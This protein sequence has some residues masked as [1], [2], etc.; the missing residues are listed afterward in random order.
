MKEKLIQFAWYFSIWFLFMIFTVIVAKP[1]AD[2]NFPLPTSS[3]FINTIICFLIPYI[4][5]RKFMD[6]K[7]KHDIKIKDIVGVVGIYFFSIVVLTLALYSNDNPS[8][9]ENKIATEKIETVAEEEKLVTEQEVREEQERLAAEQKAR[10]E[11][12]RLAAEQKER[13]EQEKL[14]AEQKAR[15]EQEKLAAEQKIKEEEKAAAEFEKKYGTRIAKLSNENKAFYEKTY[16]ELRKEKGFFGGHKYN[17]DEAREKALERALD[18]QRQDDKKAKEQEETLARIKERMA[19]WE[20]T[21]KLKYQ[22]LANGSVNVILT[23]TADFN[24]HSVSDT[25]KIEYMLRDEEE[26]RIIA[27]ASQCMDM[28]QDVKDAGIQ[29]DNFEIHLRG[30]AIDSSGYKSIED[31]VICEIPGNKN[32]KKNDPISFY[33]SASRFWIMKSK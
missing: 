11:Q 24:L 21:G 19:N 22:Y 13:E 25:D 29:A 4:I 5:Y 8:A 17:E 2:N 23:E 31:I 1:L 32:F 18:R 14:A 30:T 20:E 7:A 26:K 6:Y 33:N 9:T 15:E 16:E 12:E 27:T 28:V 10:E 3:I